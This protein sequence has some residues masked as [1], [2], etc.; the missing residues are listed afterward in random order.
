MDSGNTA[1]ILTSAALVLLM[2]PGLALFYGGQARSKNVLNMMMMVFG[3]LATVGVLWVLF[4]Y[5]VAFGT[6]VGAGLLGN[7]VEFFGLSSMLTPEAQTDGLPDLAFVAFQGMF[8]ILTTGLIAGAAADRMKFNTWMV[9]T[10]LWATLVYFPVA[11]WVFD[12]DNG[13]IA[14]GL[15]ALDF[16]GGTAVHINA[17]VAALVLCIF[18][19][20]R[21][22]WPR[23]A[24]RPHN[25][26]MVMLGAGMLWFGWF[27]FNAG[28]AGSAGW[29]ASYAFVNTIAA[30]AAAIV[31][32]LI[33]EQIRDGKPTS[34]GAAS[35]IVAGLVAITPACASVS[36]IGA[37]IIGVIAGV[38]CAYAVGLKFKLGFDDSFD[39][40][41]VHL[42]GGVIGTLMIGLLATEVAP[43][44]A[45]GL[46][47]GGGFSQL[48]IQAIAALA[49]IVYCAVVTAIIVGIL[50]ATMGLR[51][52]DDSEAT[53]IDEGE[54]AESGYDFSSL[55]GGSSLGS[56]HS[57]LSAPTQVSATAG[58]ES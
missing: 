14:A 9:F 16:A 57:A 11:H 39:V 33:V 58:K 3:T 24:M 52:D 19:G 34:L 45:N 37:M 50:K 47:Y 26:T 7:P 17:G 55:R 53:G 30:T 38:A 29:E 54:H 1:W 10:L 4:G 18:L 41:G 28:S 40:V 22:G 56:S 32:W 15:G 35:G 21:R 49:V 8:A 43:D 46:F 44:G 42:V 23:E 25:L 6:D 20:K 36:P 31:G 2:T 27:G 5:S 51:I 48:G 13:W 12:L